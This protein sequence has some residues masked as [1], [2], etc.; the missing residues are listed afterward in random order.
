LLANHS[1]LLQEVEGAIRAKVK[2]V[3]PTGRLKT[4]GTIVD[5]LK[6]ERTM[7]MSHMRDIAGIR[8][9]E[10]MTRIQQDVLV[11]EIADAVQTL[12][13]VKRI[14]R[15]TDPRHGYRAVHIELEARPYHC[16]IQVRT[17]L[18]DQWAQIVEKLGDRWGRQ[19]RYGESPNSPRQR[20]AGK[21]TREQ[22]WKGVVG[23]AE[24]IDACEVM[25]AEQAGQAPSD[26][27]ATLRATLDQMLSTIGTDI[28]EVL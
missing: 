9:V 15:R 22:L 4:I 21:V 1:R 8:I 23:L 24:V 2:H 7:A 18:Q 5:K 28:M 13:S 17:R 12:G 26:E 10:E 19:I 3:S 27:L 25:A 16:E 11:D 20:V 14:D 6:R